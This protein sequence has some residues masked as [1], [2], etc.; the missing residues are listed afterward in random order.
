MSDWYL[1]A[2]WDYEN[3]NKISDP[4]EYHQR[5]REWRRSGRRFMAF[6]QRVFLGSV[7]FFLWACVLALLIGGK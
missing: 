3:P 4:V 2:D 7:L 6:V 1:D 5:Y